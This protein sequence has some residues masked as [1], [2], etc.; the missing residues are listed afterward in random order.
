MRSLPIVFIIL[1]SLPVFSQENERNWSLNGYIKDMVTISAY[2]ENPVLTEPLY[3]DNLIHQR[4]NFK[5]YFNDNWSMTAGMRNRVFFGDLVSAFPNY[6][7][8]IDTNNDYFDWSFNLVERD[9]LVINSVFDRGYI[10]YNNGTWEVRLGRQR[11]NWGT[12]V[13][14]NPNDIFNAYS[15]FDF[16]YEERPGTDAIRVVRYLGVASSIEVSTK[17]ADDIDEMVAA[18]IWKF[19]K[20][21]YDIQL[22]SGI[23]LGDYVI[24]AGWAGNLGNASFKGELSYFTPY[25]DRI[26]GENGFSATTGIDYS[27]KNGV[28]VMG[29][30]LYNSGGVKSLAPGQ[31]A[32]IGSTE[33][34]SAK[35]LM[36]FKNSVIIM[37]SYPAT[38]L[39]NI[40]LGVM[41]F[42]GSDNLFINPTISFSV[43]QTIDLG[44]FGQLFYGE[45]GNGNYGSIS[46]S[47]FLR[48][49][50]S[51]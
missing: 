2:D 29:S 14:W 42:P 43:T 34:L 3:I 31:T 47:G 9:N 1:L 39:M 30:Y 36:P 51:F 41:S 12:T 8:L 40:G 16:D 23:A 21:S 32:F 35:N 18:A 17:I 13:V 20:G 45:K 38:P 48:F 7:D 6:S 11:I 19:N 33:R 15:F 5:W 22:L 26:G 28:Y 50:W 10:E 49:K 25:E 24:G 27:F 4:F 37:S 44:I 46:N